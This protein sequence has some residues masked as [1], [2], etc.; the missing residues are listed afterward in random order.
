M[1]LTLLR[2]RHDLEPGLDSLEKY[3]WV[4]DYDTNS[5]I[6]ISVIKEYRTFDVRGNSDGK[7]LDIILKVW[8]SDKISIIE[9]WDCLEKLKDEM[10]DKYEIMNTEK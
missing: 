2:K 8:Y 1:K 4:E 5:M 9:Y 7:Q 6:D 10:K 3:I